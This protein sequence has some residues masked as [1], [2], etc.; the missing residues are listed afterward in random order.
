[1]LEPLLPSRGLAFARS[2]SATTGGVAVSVLELVAVC[3]RSSML[4]GFGRGQSCSNLVAALVHHLLLVVLV[5]LHLVMVGLVLPLPL[6]VLLSR[7][8]RRVV[9]L[10]RQ[11]W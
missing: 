6:P 8:P 10:V 7:F 2:C 11:P 1:M 5:V 3:S 9:L 4:E